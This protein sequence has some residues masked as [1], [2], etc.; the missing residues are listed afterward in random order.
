MSK[1]LA[2]TGSRISKLLEEEKRA[3]N[4]YFSDLFQITMQARSR[5]R[6]TLVGDAANCAAA[7]AG[8][9][10]LLTINGTSRG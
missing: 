5:G 9:G 1:H 4:F 7:A 3:E 2:G 6:V 8:M 10:G